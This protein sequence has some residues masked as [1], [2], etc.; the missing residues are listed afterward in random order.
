MQ[1]LGLENLNNLL[2]EIWG[3]KLKWVL[4]YKTNNGFYYTELLSDLR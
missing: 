3:T 2:K 4:K 1:K